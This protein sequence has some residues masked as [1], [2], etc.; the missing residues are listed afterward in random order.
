[1]ERLKALIPTDQIKIIFY[2]REPD[3]FLQ[4]YRREMSRHRLPETIDS[5]CFAYTAA[6]TWLTKFPE[7]IANFSRSFG[8][9]NVVVIDYDHE[10]KTHGNVIPSFIRALDIEDAFHPTS[11]ANLFLN[12]ATST[13]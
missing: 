4:S 7:R 11:W 1:M 9:E 12:T 10:M 13:T 3:G 6:D 2:V 8:A 5:D